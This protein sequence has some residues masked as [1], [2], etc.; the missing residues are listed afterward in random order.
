MRSCDLRDHGRPGPQEAAA[1]G[2][3]PG[4]QGP[5]APCLRAH[6]FRA[7]RLVGLG[8][9]G[10]RARRHREARAHGPQ[11][12]HVE[13]DA[14]RPA[15]RVGHLRRPGR[16]PEARGHGR[17]TGPVQGHRRQ[18]RLLPVDPAVLVPRRRPALGG[19]GPQPPH[20][21]GVAARHHREALRP[22]PGVGARAVG[23]DLP[24]LRRVR[25]LPDRPLPGQG[26][27]SEHHGDA[28][29]EHDVRAPVEGQLRGLRADHDGGGHRHRHAG[30]LLRRHRG[31][32]RRHPE[33]P[34][35]AHG[36]D[37]HGGARALHA[38]GDQDGEGEGAVRGAPARGPGR[39]DGARPV[40]RRVAGRAAGARLPGGGRHP[41]G[42]DD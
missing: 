31:G 35:P 12:A 15:F 9:R 3:R 29:R 8:L 42:L 25:R 13:P 17:R 28:F 18:P 11:R 34:A 1:R 41:R 23:R 33:P 5:A 21:P 7:P 39:L 40:R 16:L 6:G 36:P 14:L 19:D 22:R 20:G 32:P 2:L 38:R 27:R 26:D 4:Q 24:D 30:G 37:G 10:L